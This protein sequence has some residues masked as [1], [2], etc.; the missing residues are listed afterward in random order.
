MSDFA[1]NDPGAGEVTADEANT[2]PQQLR[3]E[4]VERLGVWLAFA[5]HFPGNSNIRLLPIPVLAELIYRPILL[6][7]ITTPTQPKRTTQN[8][9][10]APLRTANRRLDWPGQSRPTASRS[11]MDTL[12]G[13]R[14]EH[15]ECLRRLLEAVGKQVH[16]AFPPLTASCR[17]PFGRPPHEDE[18]DAPGHGRGLITPGL[19]V[20]KNVTS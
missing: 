8:I 7:C 12:M 4:D 15:A 6:T 3:L 18:D 19:P 11:L 1:D 20:M 9:P 5:I 10:R 13:P 17:P 2:S 16:Q 14:Q